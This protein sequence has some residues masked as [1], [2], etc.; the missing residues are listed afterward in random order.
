[1]T[2]TQE[3]QH[4]R[5]VL[6]FTT[7]VWKF[8]PSTDF[9]C[10]CCSSLHSLKYCTSVCWQ[11]KTNKQTKKKTSISNKKLTWAQELFTKLGN[12]LLVKYAASDRT[13][14][15]SLEFMF[16]REPH[17]EQAHM[18][19]CAASLRPLLKAFWTDLRDIV[20]QMINLYPCQV[21]P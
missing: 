16:L 9:Y 18:C 7:C 19:L 1:M 21:Q 10:S 11:G 3:L 6:F 4:C 14:C 8:V 13:R 20:N 12:S 17:G 15:G 5:T 2:C